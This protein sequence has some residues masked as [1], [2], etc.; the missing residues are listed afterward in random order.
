MLE[1]GLFWIGV[2]LV[3]AA[4][5]MLFIDAFQVKK[6]WA[7]ISLLLI[8]P[9]FIHM[10][11]NWSSLNVRKSMYILVIGLL[12]V[13]VSVSGGAL[14]KLSLLQDNQAVQV[15]EDKIAPPEDVP[16]S[17]QE[18]A[19]T[20][21]LSVDENY[22]PLLTGSQYEQL[23]TKEIVPEKISQ[24]VRKSGP[25]ARYE[26]VLEDERIHAVNKRVRVT[27]LDGSVIEGKLTE[28]VD[29]S[30]IVESNVNGGSLGLSY[31][32]NQIQSV[33]VRLVEGERLYEPKE[34]SVDA[35]E[36]TV[37]QQEPVVEI[38]QD[39]SKDQFVPEVPKTE[40]EDSSKPQ[41]I[42]EVPTEELP[43]AIILDRSVQNEVLEK[44]EEIVDDT[45]QLDTIDG[46]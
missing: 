44:V 46:Q 33:A 45:Q 14:S 10:A 30:L 23:E 11:L 17:N 38:L 32:N 6:L 21:S 25:K 2:G 24:V 37:G 1:V 42:L 22:D 39:S 18:Q 43:T 29:D 15:L 4:I 7:V 8:V 35:A 26:L 34:Q 36:P 40:L 3:I 20:A 12:T 28:V 31:K 27:M 9:L 13:L 16:L 19:D 41:P 5:I